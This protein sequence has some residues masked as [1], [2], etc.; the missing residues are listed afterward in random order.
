M[1]AKHC[2]IALAA[3]MP[4]ATAHGVITLIYGDNGVTMPGLTV[5]DGTPRDCTTPACGAQSDTAIYRGS[6]PLG[7]LLSG[8][9]VDPAKNFKVFENHMSFKR[10]ATFAGIFVTSSRP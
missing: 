6:N 7:M 9:P 10:S 3:I 1:L 4:L 2:T 8:T 5:I